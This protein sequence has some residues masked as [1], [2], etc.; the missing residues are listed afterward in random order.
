MSKL[1]QNILDIYSIDN[2]DGISFIYDK[3][4]QLH[5]NEKKLENE[6][7]NLDLNS[8]NTELLIAI[9]IGLNLYL[10]KEHKI[11]RAYRERGLFILSE[12]KELT[13]SVKRF[14]KVG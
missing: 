1:T 5:K 9:S 10:V 12:R 3:I 13:H 14:F 7:S 6:I 8:L 4:A 11:S 2:D